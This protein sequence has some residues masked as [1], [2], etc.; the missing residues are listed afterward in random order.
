MIA[1]GHSAERRIACVLGGPERGRKALRT[2]ETT[3]STAATSAPYYGFMP[4]PV[5]RGTQA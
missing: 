5:R 1:M 2:Q 4:Y 3:E